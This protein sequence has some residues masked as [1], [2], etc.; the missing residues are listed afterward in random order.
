MNGNGGSTDETPLV[1]RRT[2]TSSLTTA[3]VR[4]VATVENEDTQSLAPLG[5]AVD[6]E[7]LERL[8]D[9]PDSEA[10]VTVSYAGYRVVV[11]RDVV[12]V[13]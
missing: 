3:I 1:R 5:D 13:Y 8:L 10:H 11:T 7:A 9:G 12:E 2:G 4:A 6:A